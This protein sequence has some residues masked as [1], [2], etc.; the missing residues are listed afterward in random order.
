MDW[1]KPKMDDSTQIRLADELRQDRQV[2]QDELDN[3]LSIALFDL[4]GRFRAARPSERGELSRRYAV[5]I[6]E[7]EKAYAYFEQYVC[8]G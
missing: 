8:E 3:R 1:G 7:L 5:V 2:A 4:L 6:T